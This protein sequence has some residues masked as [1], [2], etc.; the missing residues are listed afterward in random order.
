MSPVIVLGYRYY[1][2]AVNYRLAENYFHVWETRIPVGNVPIMLVISVP[3]EQI[4]LVKCVRGHI[5]L[6]ETYITLTPGLTAVQPR[7][8]CGN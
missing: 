4:S 8:I 6:G 1:I 2:L 5:F 7:P 3:G